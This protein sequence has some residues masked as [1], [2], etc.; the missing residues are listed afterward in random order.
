MHTR[1]GRRWGTLTGAKEVEEEVHPVEG[2]SRGQGLDVDAV[3]DVDR[4]AIDQAP[5]VREVDQHAHG[6][7]RQ[8]FRPHEPGTP[9][10]GAVRQGSL[11]VRID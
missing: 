3:G 4:V 10:G 5:L 2:H 9:R 1:G 6:L 8:R 7:A 11:P